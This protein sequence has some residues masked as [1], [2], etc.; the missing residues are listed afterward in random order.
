[1]HTS[2]SLGPP[3]FLETCQLTYSVIVV[4]NHDRVST[5]L[6]DPARVCAYTEG[7]VY[8]QQAPL[9]IYEYFDFTAAAEGDG[10]VG[11][12]PFGVRHVTGADRHVTVVDLVNNRLRKELSLSPPVVCLSIH[13]YICR[14]AISIAILTIGYA[15]FGAFHATSF[16]VS[17]G[18]GSLSNLLG[19]FAT[20][21]CRCVH[22]AE[23]T[24]I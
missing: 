2:C 6:D 11:A 10:G 13:F 9:Y 12:S 7:A 24:Y 1:M 20:T 18:C 4:A 22:V 15:L 5:L 19:Q 14:V 21:D 23:I 3:L 8:V 16:R 17:R